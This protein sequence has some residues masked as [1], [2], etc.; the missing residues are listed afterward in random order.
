[1]R[2]KNT[3]WWTP[4]TGIIVDCHVFGKIMIGNNSPN[5]NRQKNYILTKRERQRSKQGV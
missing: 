1:L 2:G 5:R 3:P 4:N